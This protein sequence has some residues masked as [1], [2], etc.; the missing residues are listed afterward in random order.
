[1][2]SDP[3]ARLPSTMI[4]AQPFCGASVPLPATP[5]PTNGTPVGTL[6]GWTRKPAEHDVLWPETSVPVMVTPTVSSP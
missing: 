5:P 1:M 4:P 2:A 6:N 3:L